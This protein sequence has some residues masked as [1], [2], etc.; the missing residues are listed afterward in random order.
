MGSPGLRGAPH[1]SSSLL[2]LLATPPSEPPFP[3]SAERLMAYA[4]SGGRR[5]SPNSW[6]MMMFVIHTETCKG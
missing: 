5:W 1:T 4:E 2:V 3:G 6:S